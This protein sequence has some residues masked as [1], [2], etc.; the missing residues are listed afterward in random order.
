MTALISR[1][2][3]LQQ[4]RTLIPLGEARLFLE[5]LLGLSRAQLMAH[6]DALLSAGEQQDFQ[7]WV[8]RRAAGEP[9]AYI[10]GE[11][12]FYGRTFQV[13][14]ATLIPRHETELLVELALER[15]RE[16][17]QPALVLDMG[18]GSG[19]IAITLALECPEAQVVATDFSAAALAMAQRNAQAL[20][21]R[22]Q[23]YQGSW[24]EALPS[25]SSPFHLIVSN[26]PY[27][28]PGDEHLSQ[29][30]LRFEPSSALVGAGDGLDDIRHI[31]A[32][33]PQHLAP[34][35]HLLFEHGY[36]QGPDSRSLLSAAGFQAAHTWT[37]LAGVD[38]VSGGYVI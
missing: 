1:R 2:A 37:D 16:R 13:S 38:R 33:A 6:D 36:H 22:V 24:Y 19:I 15:L 26:P 7:T 14:P 34:G 27:I 18:T 4:A 32:Q 12:E 9:V 30:D 17:P 35:G 3:A 31:I 25:D 5:R 29:G 20:G 28:V 8:A 23:F 10:L 21:A 11:R